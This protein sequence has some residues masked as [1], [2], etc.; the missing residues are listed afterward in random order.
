MLSLKSISIRNKLIALPV[1]F[2][3]ALLSMVGL[4]YYSLSQNHDDATVINVAGRQRMLTKKFSAEELARVTV[5][6]SALANALVA[7]KTAD[8]YQTSLDA[9]LKGGT[10]Y[11]DLGMTKPIQLPTPS[12][13]P[14][15]DQLHIVQQNWQ[16]QLDLARQLEAATDD[17]QRSQLASRFLLQNH[18]AMAEMN[19]AVGIYTGYAN[20]KLDHLIVESLQLGALFLAMIIGLSWL[21]VSDIMKPINYLVLVSRRISRGNLQPDEEITQY[22]TANEVGMLAHHIEL[23]RESLQEALSD[24]H[25]ASSSITLSSNQVSE[26]ASQINASNLSEQQRFDA[27]SDSASALKEASQRLNEISEDTVQ[28]VGSCFDLSENASNLVGENIQMMDSTTQQTEKA[29]VLIRDLSQTA[30]QVYGIVDAIRAISEQTNLL[31]LNAA[32]EAARA[33]EQGRGFA[34]VADEVRTLAARTGESTDEIASLITRLTDGVEQV[35]TSMES[36]SEKVND[37]R[38]KSQETAKGINQVRET[39]QSVANSQQ[40]V[41]HQIEAQNQHLDVMAT[42]QAELHQ[43]IEDSHQ[44][45]ETSSMVADQLS[46]VSETVGDLLDRFDLDTSHHAIQRDSN[47]KR[48]FPRLDVAL[49]YVLTQGELRAQGLTQD[50]SMGGLKVVTALTTPFNPSQPVGLSISYLYEGQNKQIEVVGRIVD[51]NSDAGQ[52]SYHIEYQSLNQDQRDQ[53]QEIFAYKRMKSE[54][55]DTHKRGY[56]IPDPHGMSLDNQPG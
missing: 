28:L 4:E 35:V 8:L 2:A 9:L 41:D 52:R 55:S 46:K 16:Q 11:A 37:S 51:T 17:T 33:G 15:I 27:M 7:G 3:I 43:I 10:T 23:M 47:D 39:I 30:E 40:Q 38:T 48:N 14:F 5:G 53:L 34:V 1:F 6:E 21:L 24:V 26:L 29:S 54:F 42:S 36:V 12:Y 31:A 49:S 18:K 20:Q 25:K 32:I 22:I 13:K 56:A 44:K 50:V 19:K 45:T